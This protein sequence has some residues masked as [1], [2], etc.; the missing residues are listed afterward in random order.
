LFEFLKCNRENDDRII[1]CDIGDYNVSVMDDGEY[2]G[3]LWKW[4]GGMREMV[5]D[6]EKRVERD[7]EIIMVMGMWH[8]VMITIDYE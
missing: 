3:S 4:K 1:V 2:N 5:Q 8:T 7:E 6:W